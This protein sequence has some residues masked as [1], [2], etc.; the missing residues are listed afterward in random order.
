MGVSKW[1]LEPSRTKLL[2]A[3]LT[4]T[5]R[6]FVM[7]SFKYTPVNG[8]SPVAKLEEYIQQCE[9]TNAWDASASATATGFAG[10]LTG[11]SSSQTAVGLARTESV[12]SGANRPLT[13]AMVSDPKRPQF[14]ASPG[15]RPT[16]W[17]P[18]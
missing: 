18:Q 17:R 9:Q 1:R 2:I 4:P 11:E 6:R 14:Q 15:M 7:Q 12:S 10:S 16:Q 8:V 5:R 3:R 13:A